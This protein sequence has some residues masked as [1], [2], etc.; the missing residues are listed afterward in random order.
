MLMPGILNAKKK[1]FFPAVSSETALGLI[2][3][4]YGKILVLVDGCS[5]FLPENSAGE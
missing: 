3:T 2:E 4:A 1:A 5:S